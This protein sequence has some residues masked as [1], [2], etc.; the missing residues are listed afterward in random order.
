MLDV[1]V[2]LALRQLLTWA[3][4]GAGSQTWK[5]I[6]LRVGFVRHYELDLSTAFI[7]RL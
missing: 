3:E 4:W 1:R 2:F 5:R 7:F 6:L